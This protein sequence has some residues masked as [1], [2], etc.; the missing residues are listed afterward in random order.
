M[1]DEDK[2][3]Q[4]CREKNKPTKTSLH[5]QEWALTNTLA[6]VDRRDGFE[7]GSESERGREGKGRGGGEGG[8][9]VNVSA[10]PYSQDCHLAV[11]M[12]S[13]CKALPYE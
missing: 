2:D 12:K 9:D 6:S 11:I 1:H 4:S 5:P 10:M 13:E 8:T 3:E 7:S